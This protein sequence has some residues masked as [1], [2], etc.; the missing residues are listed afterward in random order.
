[1]RLYDYAPSGNCL[2]ARILLGLLDVPYERVETD[3][4]GG[5]TL[6]DAFGAL[7]PAREVPV[8]ELDDG[9]V[10]TQSNAIL[11]HL[12]EGTAFLPGDAL[13][14]ARILQWLFF[15]Q[16]M[17]MLPIGGGRFRMITGRPGG[18]ER[19]P[20]ARAGLGILDAHLADREWIVGGVPTIADIS[21]YAYAQLAPDVGI[22]LA[23]HARVSRWLERLRALPRFHDDL[24]PYPPNAWP[25]RSRSVYD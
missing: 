6:T 5:D 15:E 2:K 14:R 9:T 4:F 18:E 1:M 3:I 10:L 12:A 22:D 13:A 16:D 20:K 8:L 25:G 21:L 17:V 24:V 19:V 11:F 7:N 23:G